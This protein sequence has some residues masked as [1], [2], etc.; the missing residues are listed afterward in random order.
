MFLFYIAIKFAAYDSGKAGSGPGMIWCMER[1]GFLPIAP[2]NPMMSSPR[3][4]FIEPMRRLN[5]AGLCMMG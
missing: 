2:P 4:V 3:G 1:A 5:R